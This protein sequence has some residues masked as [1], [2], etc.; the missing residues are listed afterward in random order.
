MSAYELS[1]PAIAP[2]SEA[3][4]TSEHRN[5]ARQEHGPPSDD[6]GS[7]VR[8]ALPDFRW[9]QVETMRYKDEGSAPFRDV[10]RQVLF[11]MPELHCEWRYFEVAPGG[12]STLECHEH[13]HAVMI[14]RGWGRGLVGN[15]VYELGERDLVTVPPNTWHQFRAAA[16][17]PL[18]F[19]CLVNR[20]RDRPRLPTRE[21]V[22]RLCG[23][24]DIAEFIR[25]A[26]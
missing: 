22:D 11:Q 12:H 26:S 20:E 16:D 4:E 2:E 5:Q 21:D 19:L 14:V 9:E 17:A 24:P 1:G 7:P 18:G 3:D 23:N 10:T 6:A 15:R 8:R 25:T 13:A